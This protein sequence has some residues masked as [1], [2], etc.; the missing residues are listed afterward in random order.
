MKN[1]NPEF[2]MFVGPMFSGKTTRLF[3]ITER[4]ALRG[5]GVLFIKPKIDNR[6]AETRIVNH[7]DHFVPAVSVSS[8]KEIILLLDKKAAEDADYNVDVIA[9]DE[10]FMI[11]GIAETLIHLFHQGFGVYVSSI[12]LSSGMMPFDEVQKMMPYATRIEKCTSICLSCGEDAHLT[13]RTN[14]SLE[15][16]EVGGIESYQPVCWQCYREEQQKF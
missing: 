6:Y 5:H 4:H 10:A 1:K 3:S 16:I 11:D 12:E 8:G 2:V 15:L 13:K 7:K 14:S 9:V